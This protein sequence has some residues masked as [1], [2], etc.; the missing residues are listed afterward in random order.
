MD[1]KLIFL[2]LTQSLLRMEGE[3]MGGGPVST[4][5]YIEHQSQRQKE[6]VQLPTTA[7]PLPRG[8]Q[9]AL[10]AVHQEGLH[11]NRPSRLP[12]LLA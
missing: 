4:D 8:P 1:R 9:K 6:E 2:K 7:L 11:G 3:K 10:G 12:K 5:S